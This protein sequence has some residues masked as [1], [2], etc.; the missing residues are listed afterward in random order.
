MVIIILVWGLAAWSAPATKPS[1]QTAAQVAAAAIPTPTDGPLATDADVP[2]SRDEHAP[3]LRSFTIE[4]ED[5]IHIRFD[6]PSLSLD[7][8]PRSAPGLGWQNSWDKVAMY[9]AVTSRTAL[10]PCRLAGRPWLGAFAQNDVVVFRPEA[11]EMITWQLTIVDSR[12]QTAFTFTGEG[13]PPAELAWDGRRQDGQ[14]AWPGLIYSYMM[15][16]VDP[17]GNRR[18]F[19]GRGFELPAYRLAG[20][21]EDVL[22][23]AGNQLDSRELIEDT[24]SWLNQAPGL[25]TPIEIRATARSAEQ[26]KTMA[27][28]AVASLE[29]RLCGDP[30]RLKTSIS[31]QPD[32]PDAGFLIIASNPTS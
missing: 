30:G 5:R 32:A 27:R 23:M 29:G 3:A 28:H 12:G 24:A 18:T 15:E 13:T 2:L 4:G 17:A 26:A 10:E 7:L 6:R 31:V 22:V 25:T 19:A 9:P 20:Q 14:P 21:Q 16:T 11:P 8:D 1:T